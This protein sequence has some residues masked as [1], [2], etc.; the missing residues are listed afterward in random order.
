[1][2]WDDETG[3][4]FDPP[5]E[6]PV[7]DYLRP[8]S[9]GRPVYGTL[10]YNPRNKSW[11]LSGSPEMLAVAA[12]LFGAGRTPR[13]AVRV[14]NSRQAVGELNWFMQRYPLALLDEDRYWAAL[15]EATHR[16]RL[17]ERQRIEPLVLAPGEGEFC[18]EL[19]DYQKIGA[20]FL[21]RMG[22]CLLA[23]EMGL[24]KTVQAL[25]YLA[26]RRQWPVLLVVPPHLC[27]NW[28][29]ESQRFMRIEGREPTV[30]IIKGLTPYDL[31][32]C[33]VYVVHYLLL[34]GWRS[35]LRKMRFATVVFDE[36]QELRHRGTEKYKSATSIAEMAQ[37]VIGLSGTPIYNRGGEIYCVM[38]ALDRRCLGDPESFARDWCDPADDTVR[39]PEAL[40][41]WLR[42][43]G[44]MLRR[45]KA[46]VLP[47]LPPKRRL[48]AEVDA[49]ENVY[50]AV[51]AHV[52]EKLEEYR[53]APEAQ[54]GLLLE[55]VSQM[56]RQ[57]TGLAKAPHVAAFVAALLQNGE[58]VLL[59]AHH[60]KVMDAYAK[61]LA[62]Y[63]PVFI[64]GRE[65]TPRKQAA[66]TKFM[67][68][69]TR[70]CVLSLRAATGL[71]LQNASV[72]VFGELDWSPAVHS[73]AEDRA[74]RIGQRDSVLCY[75][76]V[77]SQGTDRD[78]QE[79][80][81]L[82]VSQFSG[83]MGDVPPSPDAIRACEAAAADRLWEMVNK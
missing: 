9:P 7:D 58:K 30:H 28:Q 37:D 23:D 19:M 41:E 71:N 61:A 40:G 49:D 52:K 11:I 62:A 42:R 75:Y 72:V 45:T 14:H 24:G 46:M 32:Q 35:V 70:L 64:T 20:G 79:L 53:L 56:Q 66:I 38:D 83:L 13:T 31:P 54:K 78:M 43:E 21:S 26:Q 77:C 50:R 47:Q 5:T 29:K 74:H 12:R 17:R 34:R 51:L 59:C 22:R 48:V 69:D 4:V 36:V 2:I 82:K 44:L 25:A 33:E 63:T 68:G 67:E 1:M 27:L 3:E 55:Q 65:N 6:L 57:A 18:G 10:D 73:Q 8:P 16:A 81:G 80:L 15:T 76:L 39:D 60:H